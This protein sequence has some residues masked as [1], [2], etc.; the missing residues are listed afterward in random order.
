MN[1]IGLFSIDSKYPNLALMKVSAYHKSLCDIVEWHDPLEHYDK[2]Y[3]SKIF[4][5]TPDYA[6]YINAHEIERG[7]TGYVEEKEPPVKTGRPK[8]LVIAIFKSG[9]TSVFDSIDKASEVLNISIHMIN[10][11]LYGKAKYAKGIRFQ[12]V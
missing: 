8:K 6:Y 11:V 1:R 9:R 12:R 4:S 5:Y 3:V 2:V 7:G 10:R